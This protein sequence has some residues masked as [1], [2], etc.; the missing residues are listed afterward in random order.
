MNFDNI[1]VIVIK[2][3]FIKIKKNDFQYDLCYIRVFPITFFY[4][5][6]FNY[7]TYKLQVHYYRKNLLFLFCLSIF[8]NYIYIL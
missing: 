7:I 1:F 3:L 5:K 6:V 2:F 4:F 8:I